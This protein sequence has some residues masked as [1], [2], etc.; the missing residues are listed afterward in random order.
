MTKAKQVIFGVAASLAAFLVV[1]WKIRLGEVVDILSK[2][3]YLY[4]LLAGPV[5]V[6]GVSA[7]AYGWRTLM[8]EEVS[9]S[10]AFRALNVGYLLNNLLPLRLG[11]FG[12]AYLVSRKQKLTGSQALSSVAVEHLMDLIAGSVILVGTLSCAFSA[13]WATWVLRTTTGFIMVAYTMF[14]LL[15]KSK[16]RFITFLN[17][18]FKSLPFLRADGWMGQIESFIDGLKV[19]SDYRRLS[20]AAF[21]YMMFWCCGVL[22]VW[23]LL[24]I[25]IAEASF[26][27]SSFVLAVGALSAALPSSPGSLG[28]YEAAVVTALVACRYPQST[29]LSCA[30]VSHALIFALTCLLGGLALSWEG[31]SLAGIARHSKPPLSDT[32]KP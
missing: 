2:G 13:P 8:G 5:L 18:V 3:N 30:A 24:K 31:E 1:L 14:F 19:L 9:F 26:M 21:W 6:L 28:V 15:A 23:L 29:A 4:L 25:F 16:V 22:Q 20:L 12:R 11:E 10:R 27:T 7:R 32:A 17:R